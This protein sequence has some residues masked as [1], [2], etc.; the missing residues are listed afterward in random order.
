MILGLGIGVIA[1][2][3]MIAGVNVNGMPLLYA[4]GL[5]KL[6]IVSALA[7]MAV[8]AGL[9]RLGVRRERQEMVS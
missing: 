5:G 4:I 2:I 9:R 8:G 3:G 1:G 6:T 7:C